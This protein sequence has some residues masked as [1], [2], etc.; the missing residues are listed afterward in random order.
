MSFKFNPITGELD[1]VN[2]LRNT[3]GFFTDFKCGF[4]GSE[5]LSE[6]NFIDCCS[7]PATKTR[8][9]IDLGTFNDL[10]D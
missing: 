10:C 2:P 8:Q 7:L 3:L 9:S 4:I 5:D 6:A 1:L